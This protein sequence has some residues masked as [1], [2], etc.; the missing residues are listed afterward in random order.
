M[1]KQS[2]RS[3][4]DDLLDDINRLGA[5]AD[6]TEEE[7]DRALRE[8]GLDPAQL[9]RQVIS[10]VRAV[11]PDFP[12]H[13]AGVSKTLTSLFDAGEKLGLNKFALA[14]RLGLSLGLVTKLNQRLIE[15]ST[16]PLSLVK[17]LA[18]T[19]GHSADEL[20]AYLRRPPR[21]ASGLSFKADE[22]PELP[23]PQEF[24]E[25]VEKDRSLTPERKRELLALA[26]AR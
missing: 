20:L 18:S 7:I 3:G 2:E 4:D 9:V 17:E 26:R 22:A 1:N 10:E 14:A 19:I 21:L 6:W 16:V 25:A 23:R 12:Q 5:E 8:E 11:F 15:G 13:P 24:V